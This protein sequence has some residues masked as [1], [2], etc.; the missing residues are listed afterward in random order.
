[1]IDQ[2]RRRQSSRFVI[3]A[4][5]DRANYE[6]GA[7]DEAGLRREISGGQQRRQHI[8]VD[9]TQTGDCRA[10]FL[11]PFT[12]VGKFAAAQVGDRKI[13]SGYG[14]H[15][16]TLG[17]EVVVYSTSGHLSSPK[18]SGETASRSLSVLERRRMYK[19]RGG[20]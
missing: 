15:K 4:D 8:S 5:T 11:Q 12:P 3:S 6:K 19:R 17:K 20:F 18:Y 16:G 14:P 9:G 7:V 2:L 1:M 13:S 10:I